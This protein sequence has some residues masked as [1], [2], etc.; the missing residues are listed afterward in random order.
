MSYRKKM[1]NR[2][3]RKLFKN[4][5]KRKHKKNIIKDRS[6]MRGGYRI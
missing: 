3:S 1:N 6:P 4:T 2:S 5:V